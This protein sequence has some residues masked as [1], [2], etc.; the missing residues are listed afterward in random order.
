MMFNQ[1]FLNFF[2]VWSKDSEPMI[3]LMYTLK[4][5]DTAVF[6]KTLRFF[7]KHIGEIVRNN[8]G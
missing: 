6:K 8:K 1:S 7:C 2:I 5:K 4:L 3:E